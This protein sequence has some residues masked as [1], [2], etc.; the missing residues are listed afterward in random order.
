MGAQA[1]PRLRDRVSW[2]GLGSTAELCCRLASL[3][4]L[5]RAAA[6]S[7]AV[8]KEAFGR[9][10]VPDFSSSSAGEKQMLMACGTA[11]LPVPHAPPGPGQGEEP[12]SGCWGC[13]GVILPLVLEHLWAFCLLLFS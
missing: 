1:P 11:A 12:Q 10:L 2:A 5:A 9:P 3:R 6:P 8:P 7:C 13:P 4:R